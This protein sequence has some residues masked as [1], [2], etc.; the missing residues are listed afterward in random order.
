MRQRF[1]DLAVVAGRAGG[2]EGVDDAGRQRLGEVGRLDGDRHHAGK[3]GEPRRADI[4][5]TELQ[6]LQVGDAVDVL[7]GVEAL[8]RPR[9]G[10]EQHHA[11]GLELL[12]HERLL[13][14]VQLL[15]FGIGRGEERH[16]VGAEDRAFVLQVGHQQLA[17]LRL[18]GLNRA[19][20]LRHLEQRRVG[21]NRDGELAVG[22]LLHIV[23]EGLDILG[24]VVGGGIA[25]GHVPFGLSRRR[26][27]EQ[28]RGRGKQQ[29]ALHSLSPRRFPCA[30]RYIGLRRAASGDRAAAAGSGSGRSGTAPPR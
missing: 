15:R 3:L 27:G 4:V 19:L 20:E 14:L 12:L 11:L 23:C 1:P 24:M 17:D 30:D 26:Q 6:A 28:G 22:C 16:D 10:E 13:R 25:R 29:S 2:D 9:H 21:V 5:G 7:L 18:A 8:R